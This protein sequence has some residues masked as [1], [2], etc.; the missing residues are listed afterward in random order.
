MQDKNIAIIGSTAIKQFYPDFPRDPKDLDIA[1]AS[2][3]TI[4]FFS[5]YHKLPNVEYLL[6]PILFNRYM[7]GA[8][9]PSAILTLKMSHMFWD[10]NWSKHMFDIQFLLKKGVTHNPRFLHEM[11]EYWMG[12]K[13]KIRRSELATSKED[14]FTNNVNEDVDE[15]DF[16]HTLINPV[17]MF[18]R[19]LKDGAEVELDEDK[20]EDLSFEDK[21]EVCREETMVMA[22]ERYCHKGVHRIPA[23][24]KQLKD[25]II[26]HFPRYIAVFAILNYPELENPMFNYYKKIEDGIRSRKT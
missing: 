15:H 23:F 25:N 9:H 4:D 13:D 2:Q 17:P 8:V 16:L 3:E 20:W 10:I 14:F 5:K 18:T 6:N 1:C 22:Y 26:K 11:V 7:G 21:L 24:R 19:L 12:T